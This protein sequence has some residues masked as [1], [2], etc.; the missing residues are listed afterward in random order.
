MGGGGS[1]KK[2]AEKSLELAVHGIIF[3]FTVLKS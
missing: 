1:S 3:P 2:A